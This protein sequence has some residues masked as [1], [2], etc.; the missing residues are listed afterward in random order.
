[1]NRKAF[2][3]IELLVVIAII[4]LLMSVIVPSLRKAKD[5]ARMVICANNQHQCMTGVQTYAADHDGILPPHP[6]ERKN[7]SFSWISYLNYHQDP[8]ASQNAKN[9]GMYYYLGSYLPSIEVFKCPLGRKNPSDLQDQYAN[10]KSSGEGTNMSYNYYWGGYNITM[11]DG[12]KFVGPRG[13]GDP[14]KVAGLLLSDAMS[15]WGDAGNGPEWRLAHKPKQGEYMNKD[16]NNGND[17]SIFWVWLSPQ[18]QIPQGLKMNAGYMDGSVRR[19]ASE[20]TVVDQN[21]GERF[22]IPKT[23]R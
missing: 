15:Y 17:V 9:K 8:T 23:W 2:T 1:V 13:K 11:R 18:S 12:R 22:W 20:D 3:L 10:Y 4:A 16:K 19:Y 5:A 7:G 6:A 14:K 21:Y